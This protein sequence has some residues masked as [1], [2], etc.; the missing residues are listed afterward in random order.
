MEA[1]R[2]GRW[3]LLMWGVVVCVAMAC[4]LAFAAEEPPSYVSN[5]GPDGT[6]A[7]GFKRAG[8]IAVDEPGGFVYVMDHE[9]GSLLKFD[10]QGHPVNF[11]GTSG[12][13]SENRLAGLTPLD[14]FGQA[15]VA[16]DPNSHDIY[17][18]TG[19]GATLEAFHADGEPALFSAGSSAGTNVIE[20]FEKLQ[21]VAVDAEG[22][23]YASDLNASSVKIF[24]HSGLPLTQFSTIFPA[25]LAVD[26]KG[27]VYVNAFLAKVRQYTP[28]HLP[29][30]ATTTYSQAPEPLT[31]DPSYSLA[32]DPTTNDVYVPENPASPRVVRYDEN[33]NMLSAFAGPGEEGE[34]DLS[35][36]V[37][38]HG[39]EGLIFVSNQP[40]TGL[41][42]VEIFKE[43]RYVGPPRIDSVSVSA[44]SGDTAVLR[45]EINPGSAA[46]SFS[47]EY[48]TSDCSTS[49][50][51]SLPA[52][53]GTLDPG[54]KSI[55]VAASLK[56]LK[57]GTT[58]HFRVV[59]ENEHG[60]QVGPA[61]GDHTFKTQAAAVGFRLPDGRVW[62]LV[63][64]A[65][66]RGG[67]IESSSRGLIQASTDGNGI[68]YLSTNPVVANPEGNRSIEIS[69]TLA[70]RS[71]AGWSS[72]DLTPPNQQA[73]RLVAGYEGEY[74]LFNASLSQALLEP[75]GT[76][77][78]SP[79]ATEQTAYLRDNTSPPT[80]TPLVTGMAGYAN[81]P[82]E[83][84]FGGSIGSIQV[85]IAGAN[86]AFDHVVLEST[87]PL[88][89]PTDPVPSLYEWSSGRLLR[90][91]NVLPDSEGGTMTPSRFIGSGAG[92]VQNAISDDGSRIFW[93][94]GEYDQV[95]PNGLTGLYMRDMKAGK[96]IRLD[97]KQP[98]ASGDGDPRPVFQ[99][100]NA[101][102]T[103][104]YFTDS[105]QLTTDASPSG[106]DL[107]RC[108]IEA[109]P[110]EEGCTTLTDIS[111]PAGSPPVESGEVLG[112]LPG[113]SEDGSALYF[114]AKGA[115]D[116]SMNA[117]GGSAVPGQPNLYRWDVAEGTRLIA[118]L[119][120][121]DSND[122]GVLPGK[123]G[124]TLELSADSS[125]NGRYLAF[126]SERSLT[127]F[128]NRDVGSGKPAQEAFRYDAVTEELVCVSCP[129]TG[130][131]PDAIRN[132]SYVE[133]I[134]LID[135]RQLWQD[136]WVAA[137]FPQ[138]SVTRLRG[139]ALYRPRF[140]L[141]NGRVFFNAFGGLVPADSNGEWDAYQYEAIGVG[142]CKASSEGPA[143]S[144]LETGC[145]S[146]VS[147][148][149]AEEEAALFDSSLSGDDVFFVS[150]AR[151]GGNDLDEEADIYD[152]RV[153]G[154][155]AA[156][157]P[158][159]ECT[160]GGCQ[161]L[162]AAP[163]EVWPASATFLGAGN[164]KLAGKRC[165]K[166]KRKVRRK[167]KVGCIAKKRHKKK[168]QRRPN[169]Y[170]QR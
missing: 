140:V 109:G 149:T 78:L 15:Q 88:S 52:G 95:L 59:A 87:V 13:L 50:C 166:G 99:G 81:V 53:G 18:T 141:D 139:T 113:L 169:P 49:M 102:G 97:L 144:S 151:L 16:V 5:F 161:D 39:V 1:A 82:D 108:V 120:G 24:S 154:V 135:P 153:D 7:T 61:V 57:P 27:R 150:S 93:S 9:E 38:V 136:K 85:H 90:P 11:T 25:N 131:R 58:Y 4:A 76:A 20:G 45:A 91:I 124:V 10:L 28:S 148:G 56:G 106:F 12:Y 157:T 167:G 62:E 145:V 32:V 51:A 156:S 98:G 84:K 152:A 29:V 46:S 21:G 105:Q 66:K 41:S 71:A 65:N 111:V 163:G 117:Y 116:N 155:A 162:V 73:A 134:P 94:T 127:G 96:T 6:E 77:P 8:A 121:E 37:G 47:F 34:L 42:Q 43:V 133:K 160:G 118:V 35:E 126:M 104:A 128:D 107:Y 54:F 101:D 122:W 114:V 86:R 17:V 164:L 22:S 80:Y 69:T 68:A 89:S 159:S 103:I 74:K 125:P 137:D 110:E 63:T 31:T 112:I 14:G 26:A 92:S 23:I 147:S 130:S 146:L 158:S 132:S 70:R 138:A 2:F 44:V 143:T 129:A 83:T 55:E 75:V 33:G 79:I 168:S 36:G 165:P 40:S 100:A 115:L 67:V 123:V 64:P 119:S 3:A 142:D 30:D 48:G 60:P 170:G 72:E 19:N